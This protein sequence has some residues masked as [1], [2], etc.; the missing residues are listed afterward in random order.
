MKK[1]LFG[2]LEG[3]PGG[4]WQRLGW[5]GDALGSLGQVSGASLEDPGGVLRALEAPL[6]APERSGSDSIGFSLVFIGL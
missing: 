2:D 5:L 6:E 4:S 1:S 3:V